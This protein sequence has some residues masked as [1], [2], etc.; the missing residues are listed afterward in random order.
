MVGAL[1]GAA[2]VCGV[3]GRL[4]AR[5]RPGV[6]LLQQA[7]DA[8][9]HDLGA[10]HRQAG[11][12]PG[13][14]EVD[15]VQLRAA[16]AA[17][18][19]QGRPRADAAEADQV[20]GIDRHAEMQ[21]LAAGAHDAGGPD[22]A[23]V[24]HGRGADHQQQ[25]GALARSALP[26]PCAIGASSCGHAQRRQQRAGQLGDPLLGRRDG[27]LGDAV[28]QAGQLGD[29]QADLQMAGTD[30]ASAASR[31][32]APAPR[33]P[34]ST[35]PGTANGMIL[36]V[37]T[38]SFGADHRVVGQRADGQRLVDR[39]QPVDHRGVDPQQAGH[40]GGRL[41]RPVA[42]R[43]RASSGDDQRL[44]EPIGGDVLGHV[45]GLQPARRSPRCGR[46]R[47]AR[48]SP[49][50]PAREPLRIIRSPTRWLV[51]HDARRGPRPAAR[52]RTSC[53]LRCLR[54]NGA[55]RRTATISAMMESAI[56]GAV[57]ASMF[58]PTGPLDARQRG[59]V[60]AEFAQ[61]L[62]PRGMGA[63]GAERADVEGLRLQ[64]AV[65]RRVVQLR[66]VR[67]GDD[68]GAAVRAAARPSPRPAR[69]WRP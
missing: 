28:L 7:A 6:D 62:Q 27:L 16:G 8:H 44:G 13:Q 54:G 50:R 26:A 14:H 49:L 67:Q 22:V 43:V 57:T 68:G 25:I 38:M 66:I 5:Q 1:R 65:Q 64:R 37:A 47:A 59:V 12:Q 11:E 4:L 18:Q 17:G 48:R 40:L 55:P 30:A 3:A 9:A 46:P 58:R 32:A 19:H 53:R 60:V 31:S 61:P 45:A 21:D 29:D 42:A 15:A 23:P 36:I 63:A 51:R 24:H 69:R 10:A 20:A 39:V 34:S 33:P 2:P 41:T 35:L 52:G 56:S